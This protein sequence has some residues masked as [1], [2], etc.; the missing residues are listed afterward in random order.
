MA[1]T[2]GA[3]LTFTDSG[4]TEPCRA[5]I[6]YPADMESLIQKQRKATPLPVNFR[7]FFLR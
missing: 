4:M 6:W 5:A 7:C 2:D 1:Q 3:D